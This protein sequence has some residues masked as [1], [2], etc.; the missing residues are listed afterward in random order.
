MLSILT[1]LHV[2]FA[3]TLIIVILLQRS[4]TDSLGGMGGQ[5]QPIFSNRATSGFLTKLTAILFALFA[6]NCL[7]LGKLTN[8]SAEE[9]LLIEN[10]VDEFTPTLEVKHQEP[11]VVQKKGHKAKD[12]PLI[13]E[14]ENSFIPND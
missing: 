3:I 4:G 12:L 2:V 14:D 9:P 6:L 7:V 1:V 10:Y 13:E 8:Q 5:A 11:G